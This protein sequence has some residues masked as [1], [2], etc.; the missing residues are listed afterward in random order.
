[1]KYIAKKLLDLIPTLLGIS[2]V[3]FFLIRLIPGDPVLNLIGERGADPARYLEMKK[4]LGLDLPIT[5]QFW[6]YLKSIFRGDIGTSIISN[7]SV[8]N[9]F[10]ERFPATLELGIVALIGATVIGIPVGIFAAMKR[11]SFFDYF[12]MSTSLVGY[13]MPIFWWGLILILLFSVKMGITPVS[14]RID[15]IYDIPVFSGLYLIDTLRPEVFSQEGFGPFLSALKH[16]ILPSIALGTIPLAV[17]ARMTRSSML[18]VLG[19]DYIRTAKAKGM[20]KKRIIYIHA[21]RNALV[22]IITTLALLFGSII[23]GAIL[24]ETI[25]SWPGIGKWIVASITARDYPVIQGGVLIISFVI[26]LTNIIVDIIYYLL[27]PKMRS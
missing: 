8:W 4:A 21:L 27:N 25:F 11:N 2:L 26:V 20:S 22:P 14:G 15:F 12:L 16:L 24:T 3:C 9:E 18:E 23:T 5:E 7:N 6:I 19:E 13:S 10:I 1:M 17:I